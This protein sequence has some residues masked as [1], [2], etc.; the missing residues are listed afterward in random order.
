M[1]TCLRCH[2][3]LVPADGD[4]RYCPYCGAI[5]VLEDPPG[6]GSRGAYV[7]VGR[8]VIGPGTGNLYS[9]RDSKVPPV[10]ID[11]RRGPFELD[12]E[13]LRDLYAA[14]QTPFPQSAVYGYGATAPA[15]GSTSEEKHLGATLWQVAVRHTRLF[16][17]A[18]GSNGGQL[19]AL[20]TRNLE[21]AP[22]WGFPSWDGATRQTRLLVSE[23]LVYAVLPG[24]GLVGVDVGRGQTVLQHHLP[25]QHPRVLIAG[26]EVLV[27]GDVVGGQQRVERY[28]LAAGAD[29]S[30]AAPR[31]FDLNILDSQPSLPDPVRLGQDFIFAAADGKLYRWT[32]GDDARPEVLWPNPEAAPLQPDWI[33]LSQDRVGFLARTPDRTVTLFQFGLSGGRSDIMG[34]TPLPLLQHAAVCLAVALQDTLYLPVQEPREPLSVYSLSLGPGAAAQRLVSLPGTQAAHLRSFQIVPWGGEPYLLVHYALDLQQDFWVIHPQTGHAQP[35]GGKPHVE[36]DVRIVWEAG[37]AWQVHLTEG[38][39]RLL[40]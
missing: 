10:R 38:R 23:T 32:A 5:R 22:G 9:Y 25:Y 28:D 37:Q 7:V 11:P 20:D 35:V 40:T 18:Q 4:H 15:P 13:P 17:L 19:Q 27:L 26:G 29:T 12:G 3:S 39:I 8:D 24:V 34:T 21:F 33:P 14:S 6:V 30:L 2:R 16:A 31:F 1:Q 36:D